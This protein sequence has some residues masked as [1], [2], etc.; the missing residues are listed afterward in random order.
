MY[1]RIKQLWFR[2]SEHDTIREQFVEVAGYREHLEGVRRNERI[3][4]IFH[5]GMLIPSKLP[6]IICYKIFCKINASQLT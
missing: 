1:T 4:I 2:S 3:T 5:S 6:K